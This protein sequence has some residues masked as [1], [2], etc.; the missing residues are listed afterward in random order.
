M[1]SQSVAAVWPM[2]SKGGDEDVEN[3]DNENQAGG[4]V[5]GEVQPPVFLLIVQ[6]PSHCGQSQEVLH[7]MRTH[8]M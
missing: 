2:D 1:C 3:H 4:Q 8:T 7:N 6:V 5:L